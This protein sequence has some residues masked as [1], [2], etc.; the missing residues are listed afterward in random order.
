MHIAGL[1]S[2]R[3]RNFGNCVGDSIT[4]VASSAE[5]RYIHALSNVLERVL[6]I[7]MRGLHNIS[8]N[9]AAQWVYTEPSCRPC[10]LLA[11]QFQ[12]ALNM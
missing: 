12:D 7:I 4:G 5:S 10:R 11:M 3:K 6:N 1:K 2:Q 8:Q 9:R